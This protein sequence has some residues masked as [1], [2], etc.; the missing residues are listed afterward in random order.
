MVERAARAPVTR[1][2]VWPGCGRVV[3]TSAGYRGG[4]GTTGYGD[5]IDTLPPMPIVVGVGRSGTTLLR[6]MLDAHPD[7]CIPGETGFLSPFFDAVRTGVEVDAAQFAHLVTSHPTWPDLDTDAA[8]YIAAVVRLAPFSLT[9]GTREFYRRYA[10]TRGK[11]RWG[12]KTPGYGQFVPEVLGVLPEAYFVHIIRDGRDVAL[13]LRST[14]FSPTQDA[15]GLARHWAGQIRATRQQAAG[16]DCYTEVRYEDL[17]AQPAQTLRRICNAIDLDYDPAMLSYH[18]AAAGRL[19]EMRDR[20]LPDGVTLITRQRRLDNHRFA[21]RPP[22][23][24]RSGRWRGEMSVVE[25]DAFA[26]EAGDLLSDLG[27]ET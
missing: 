15:A 17:L 20:L 4:F 12:D 7:L 16:R 14:W 19:S 10:A 9:E 21:S 25:Q 22:D 8:E 1:P 6:L 26:A 2:V 23:Q 11:S 27:Y 24:T 13:S 3:A 18:R 5:G